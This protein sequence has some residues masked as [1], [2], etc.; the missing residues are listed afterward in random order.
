MICPDRGADFFSERCC[1]TAFG[2]SYEPNSFILLFGGE[3]SQSC[4]ENQ[5]C[6][7]VGEANLQNIL[8]D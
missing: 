8:F 2:G 6:I 3:K 1:G 7:H 5:H 4:A